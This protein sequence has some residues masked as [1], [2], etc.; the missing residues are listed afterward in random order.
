MQ[1]VGNNLTD[2]ILPT[3]ISG[4]CDFDIDKILFRKQLQE[5]DKPEDLSNRLIVPLRGQTRD[6]KR[7]S[8]S[9]NRAILSNK[10]KLTSAEQENLV[11]L[12]LKSSRTLNFDG[13]NFLI[14]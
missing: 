1:E 11:S 6:K 10:D 12:V 14:Y 5:E 3:L 9:F 4:E 13:K 2:H 8:E 7:F